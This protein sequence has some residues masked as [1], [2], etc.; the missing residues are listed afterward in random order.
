MMMRKFSGAWLLFYNEY[1]CCIFILPLVMIISCNIDKRSTT[2]FALLDARHTGI[3]FYNNIS[4]TE[5][6]NP[7]TFR[8][9]F[10]GG[11]VAIGDINNDSLPDIFFCSNQ[12]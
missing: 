10:N 5:T 12:H 3:D 4:Y 11:G 7:Y 9:F 6:F 1:V 2:L 8:N